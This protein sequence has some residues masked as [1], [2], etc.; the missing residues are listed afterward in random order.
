MEAQPSRLEEIT[1]KTDETGAN[2][3]LASRLEEIT[4]TTDE[5][6]GLME[7]QPQGW[8]KSHLQRTKPGA[9][10]SPALKAGRNHPYNGRNRG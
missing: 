7:A 1:P 8:K 6:P 2:G 3:S 10:G 5:K 4:P 9:N